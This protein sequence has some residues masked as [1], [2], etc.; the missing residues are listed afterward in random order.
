MKLAEALALRSDAQKRLAQLQAR[1]VA[2]ARYQGTFRPGAPTV[3][4]YHR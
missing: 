1:A 3:S 4:V 2:S